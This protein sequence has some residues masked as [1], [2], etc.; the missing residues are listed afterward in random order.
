MLDRNQIRKP[1]FQLASLAAV[2]F[3]GASLFF[4][5]TVNADHRDYR[6][7]RYE[8]NSHYVRVTHVEPIYRMVKHREP[9]EQCWIETVERE[10]RVNNHRSRRS[11]VIGGLI[12]AAV[13]SKISSRHHS[14]H[15]NDHIGILAGSIIGASI[16]HNAGKKH[17]DDNIRIIETRDVERCETT[18]RIHREKRLI[19][20]DVSYRQNGRI[21]RTH[22]K[23]HPGRKIRVQHARRYNY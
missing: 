20:Y 6:H 1:F 9:V 11:T 17:R 19:G 16:G 2:I 22:T 23:N 21:Y 14:G 13:G 15:R 3:T 4:A 18:Y 7:D 12:G 8:R 10:R 5:S